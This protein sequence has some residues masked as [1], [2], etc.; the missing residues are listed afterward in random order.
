M[1]LKNI[2]E[3]KG[4]TLQG[5]PPYSVCTCEPV[6]LSV[7][8][9]YRLPMTISILSCSH[10]TAR[11]HGWYSWHSLLY[12]RSSSTTPYPRYYSSSSC[13]IS[14]QP[15]GQ[16]LSATDDQY[17]SFSCSHVT[18]RTHGWYS[19][20]S[21]SCCHCKLSLPLVFSLNIL[22]NRTLQLSLT[23]VSLRLA[24]RLL[25]PRYLL[26][27]RVIPKVLLCRDEE[28]RLGM[29]DLWNPLCLYI[30]ET[31]SAVHREAHE[32]HVSIRVRERAE[33]S[34]C[35]NRRTLG[36]SFRTGC[37]ATGQGSNLT[38]VLAD[39]RPL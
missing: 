34:C 25:L 27:C 32:D 7:M 29:V 2:S 28:V 22:S 37:L 23:L 3:L 10:V 1:R 8:Q 21:S 11:T 33:P 36:H 31:V 16:L 35:L 20:Q 4:F 13:S 14:R 6:C 5:I 19:C 24:W 26:C 9:C 12:R 18:A 17:P 30:L 38:G 39:G 15:L